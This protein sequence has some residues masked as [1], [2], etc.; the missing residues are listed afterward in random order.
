[1]RIPSKNE[2]TLFSSLIRV[3]KLGRE[4]APIVRGLDM[5]LTF[6]SSRTRNFDAEI[7]I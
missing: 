1:M 6:K 7:K 3:R 5:N 2:T 4:K